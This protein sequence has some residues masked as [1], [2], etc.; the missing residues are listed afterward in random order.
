M[1][2]FRNNNFLCLC[3]FTAGVIKKT[4]NLLPENGTKFSIRF[5]LLQNVTTIKKKTNLLDHL[6]IYNTLNRIG[7]FFSFYGFFAA[8]NKSL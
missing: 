1:K 3:V 6:V 7:V 2:S 8:F 5:Y 4:C